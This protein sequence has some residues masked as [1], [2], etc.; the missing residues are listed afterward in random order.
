MEIRN[1]WKSEDR[2]N[3]NSENRKT[4]VLHVL[5]LVLHVLA[6][7]V[8]TLELWNPE[9]QKF[10]IW[11]FGKSEIWKFETSE[12]RGIG[13]REI[14]EIGK[15]ERKGFLKNKRITAMSVSCFFTNTSG[16]PG[17]LATFILT[18]G[19]GWDGMVA[20]LFFFGPYL[21]NYY[22]IFLNRFRFLKYMFLHI[23]WNIRGK[24]LEFSFFQN[25]ARKW[26][27]GF[28]F[29]YLIINSQISR[30]QLDIF[31]WLISLPS[32]N[33]LKHL[34]KNQKIG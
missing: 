18:D 2:K 34:R 8:S 6:T 26:G 7:P 23:F 10:S 25:I 24:K 28:F 1:I 33:F 30:K 20:P 5:W 15:S 3:G 27:V 29:D 17:L 12:N 32:E 16:F 9:V 19:M 14:Q 31:F 11:K 13:K 4:L 21:K 22:I